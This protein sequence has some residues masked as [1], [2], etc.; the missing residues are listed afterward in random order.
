LQ[1]DLPDPGLE[2]LI[3][4]KLIVTVI[5]TL[6]GYAAGPGGNVF[7][8]PIDLGFDRYNL[9]RMQAADTMLFGATTFRQA[10]TYWPKPAHDPNAPEVEREISRLYNILEKVVVSDTLQP[11]DTG[12]WTATTEVVPR[13]SARER[14]RDLKTGSGGDILCFG[15]LTTW[16]ALLAHDLIDELH[17]LVGPG[18]IDGGLRTFQRPLDGRL[19]LQGVERIAESNL[20]ALQYHLVP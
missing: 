12:P 14:L 8:M 20:A 4:R 1:R 16:N 9:N 11:N 15:S 7:A 17:V 18:A 19:T 6:D 5:S 10:R 3:M 2:E 13:A